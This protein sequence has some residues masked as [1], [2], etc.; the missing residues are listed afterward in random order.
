MLDNVLAAKLVKGMDF[1]ESND[2]GNF[3]AMIAFCE[4]I[5]DDVAA[6]DAVRNHFDSTRIAELCGDKDSVTVNYRIGVV[7]GEIVVE[8]L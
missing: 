4:G 3:T 8:E 5:Q 2:E 1:A 6:F 7:D